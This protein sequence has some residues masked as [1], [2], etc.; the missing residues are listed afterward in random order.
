MKRYSFFIF[1]ILSFACNT[2]QLPQIVFAEDSKQFLINKGETFVTDFEFE[3]KGSGILK[4][5]SVTAACGCTKVEFPEDEILPNEH[6]KI[7]IVFDSN[8]VNDSIVTKAIL[9]EANTKPI[10]SIVELKGIINQKVDAS[11]Q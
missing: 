3:N 7:H 6:G 9:V 5:K 1:F 11:I 10:L 4:L 2:K 8:L